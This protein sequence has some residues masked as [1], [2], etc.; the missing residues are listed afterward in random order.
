M[1]VGYR[2]VTLATMRARFLPVFL[3]LLTSVQAQIPTPESFLGYKVGA[4]YKLADFQTI[5]KYFEKLDSASPRMV[6]RQI[7]KS[8]EGRTMFVAEI[9]SEKNIRDLDRLLQ[10]NAKLHDPRKI[11]DATERARLLKDAKTTILLNCSM[12]AS[13]VAAAQMSMELAYNLVS[14]NDAETKDIL[15]NCII[16]LVACANPDGLDLVKGWYDKNL[17]TKFEDAPMPYLY[18]KYIGHDNNLD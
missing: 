9:S 17:G 2:V 15:D 18:Q 5:S 3:G 10:L 16:Q 4:D 13:E 8:T 11:K 12:H 6:I 1:V 14:G 7:G